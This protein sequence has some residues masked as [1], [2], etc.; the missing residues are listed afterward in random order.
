MSTQTETQFDPAA[1]LP[2]QGLD[3]CNFTSIEGRR[4][5]GASEA[6][7]ST[8]TYEYVLVLQ[9]CI[10]KTINFFLKVLLLFLA[11]GGFYFSVSPPHQ[12]AR[13]DLEI[14]DHSEQ[15]FF[16]VAYVE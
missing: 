15:H 12:P 3:Y 9:R 11:V 16:S 5:G 13:S 2:D 8:S 4:A 14:I 10:S 1:T 6:G 7:Y